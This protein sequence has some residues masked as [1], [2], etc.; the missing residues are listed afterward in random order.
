MIFMVFKKA[1]FFFLIF[2]FFVFVFGYTTQTFAVVNEGAEVKTGSGSLVSKIAPGEFLPVSVKLVNFGGGRRVDVTIKYK[3]FNQVGTEV[4][5]ESETVAVETTANFVKILQ[6]PQDF[7]PGRYIATSSI[8]YAG[9]EVPATSQFQFNIE[10]K[11]AGIFVSQ[12]ILYGIIVLII[13]IVFAVVSRLIMKKRRTGRIVSHEYSDVPK[14][15]R[16]FYEMISDTIAQMRYRVGDKA[17]ELASDIDGLVIDENTGKVLK[18]TKNPAK[19]IALLV[20]RYENELGEKVSFALRRIDDGT[21][22]RLKPVDKN[23]VIVRKYFG[24]K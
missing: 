10:I 4:L 21:E 22:K 9:Q 17:I 20:L 6:I 16:L 1:Q 5:V 19:I 23:L 13:G 3:I 8:V 18:L 14:H 11:I 15:D 7:L 12:F 24:G 2:L